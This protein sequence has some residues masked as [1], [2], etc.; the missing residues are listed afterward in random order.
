LDEIIHAGKTV[1]GLGA[2]T[3]GNVLL[4]YSGINNLILPKIG[5]INPFKF[6]KFTPGSLIP[7]VPED[8]VLNESPDFL[9]FLPWHFRNYALEKYSS[10]LNKGGRLILPLPVVEVIGL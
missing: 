8:E 1:S 4:S 2:S 5:E 7:I 9:L 10:F 6:G 3:K